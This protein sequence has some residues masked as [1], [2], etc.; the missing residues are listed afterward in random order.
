MTPHRRGSPAPASLGG[1]LVIA[2][3]IIA[4]ACGTTQSPAPSGSAAASPNGPSAIPTDVP[5]PAGSAGPDVSPSAPP[6]QTDT[7]WGRIW[8]AVPPTFPRPPGATPSEPIGRGPSSAEYS[9]GASPVDVSDFYRRSLEAAGFSTDVSG[10]LEDGSR[11]LESVGVEPGCRIQT[12]VTPLGGTTHVT[13][14][15]GAECPYR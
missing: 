1:V 12:T 8:D 4:V 10:P 3:L 14:L 5:T 13:I 7:D 9:V 11:V 15:F 2:L 6:E